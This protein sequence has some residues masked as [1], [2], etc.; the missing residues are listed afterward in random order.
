MKYQGC[1]PDKM[2]LLRAYHENE[3]VRHFDVQPHFIVALCYDTYCLIAS[4]TVEY[5]KPLYIV[6][7]ELQDCWK[8]VR[9]SAQMAGRVRIFIYNL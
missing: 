2:R 7:P 9:I 5:S 3:V 6:Y 8:Y 1:D 4:S